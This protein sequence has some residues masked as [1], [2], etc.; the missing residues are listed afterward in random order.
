MDFTLYL[1]ACQVN[2]INRSVLLCVLCYP[3][4]V[5]RKLLSYSILFFINRF[6]II[7]TVIII[8]ITI[9]VVVVVVSSTLFIT[10][11]GLES[12]AAHIMT[13]ILLSL[14][15]TLELK[16]FLVFRVPC[17]HYFQLQ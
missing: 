6:I 15:R 1:L 12:E 2:F 13:G 7:I 16:M 17:Q 8:I 14:A 9:V 5:T 10:I 11:S 3:R 4:D